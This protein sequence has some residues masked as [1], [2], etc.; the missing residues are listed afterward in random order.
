MKIAWSMDLGFMQVDPEVRS[1]T[2]A[3]LDV[4][5][6]LGCTVEEVTVPWTLDIEKAAV[7]WYNSMHYGRQTIWHAANHAELLTSYALNYARFAASHTGLDDMA[8]S[9]DTV[10]AMYEF[11][12]PL[13]ERYDAFIC[14]TN[15]IPA[16]KADHDPANPD[17]YVNG[18]KVDPENGWIMTYPFNM[19]HNCPV[20]SVPS[21]RSP[22]T[23]VPTGIQIVGRSFDDAT[24]F[25]LASAY[26]AAAS[27]LFV[28]AGNHPL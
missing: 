7:H 5:R 21:G 25:R 3:A 17:F 24:V 6:G 28:T 8:H 4:L 2:R 27:G 15:G 20:M 19:L 16:V 23:G 12:G 9:W 10:Q 18:V 13:M 1:N 22:T 11:F 26:E 14:P